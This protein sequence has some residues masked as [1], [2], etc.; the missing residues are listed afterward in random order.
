MSEFR[1]FN[2]IEQFHNLVKS[3]EK[4]PSLYP[5]EITYQAKVKLHGT[6]ATVGVKDRKFFAQKRTSIV[7]DGH[8]GFAEFVISMGYADLFPDCY[9]YGEWIGAGIQRGVACSQLP[10]KRFCVYAIHVDKY[11][12]VDPDTI[13]KFLCNNMGISPL[14][15]KNKHIHVIDWSGEDAVKVRLHD[16][17]H[18]QKFVDSQEPII[19]AIDKCDPWMKSEFDIEGVGEGLVYYPIFDSDYQNSNETEV[20][21]ERYT[22]NWFT[23]DEEMPIDFGIHECVFSKLVFKAKGQSH[24]RKPKKDKVAI[25][26]SPEELKTRNEYVERFVTEERLNQIAQTYCEGDFD[27][28]NMGTFLREFGKDVHKES[29]DELETNEIEWKVVQ[30]PV[31]HAARAW[32]ILQTKQIRLAG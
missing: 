1:K 15:L 17:E 2:S 13:Q 14:E 26:L 10:S 8:F 20:Q 4:F 25:Q 9:I 19:Q 11:Y 30:K 22:T 29:M 32:F 5:A 12:Y 28:R 18:S 24:E 6:N 27:M 16:R 31:Q 3:A 21:G 23:E 7:E